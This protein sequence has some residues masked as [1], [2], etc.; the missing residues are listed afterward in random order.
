MEEKRPERITR[1]WLDRFL[2]GALPAVLK[3]CTEA[4]PPVVAD[5][6]RLVELDRKMSP[7]QKK[8]PKIIWFDRLDEADQIDDDVDQ[9]DKAA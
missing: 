6:V 5:F 3:K 9:I 1:A 7:V 2:K 4:K 8:V